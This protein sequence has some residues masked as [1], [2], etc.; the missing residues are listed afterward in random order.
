[1]DRKNQFGK[2]GRKSI[3]LLRMNH[4]ARRLTMLYFVQDNRLHRFPV[5]LRCGVKYNREPLRDTI[6]HGVEECICCMR[7]WPTDNHK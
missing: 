5:P 2:N 4:Y 1:M 7:R 6:P 3:Q